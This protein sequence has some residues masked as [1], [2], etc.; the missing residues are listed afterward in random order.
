MVQHKE[1]KKETIENGEVKD[2]ALGCLNKS[3]NGINNESYEDSEEE[4]DDYLKYLTVLP[5]LDES[6][7]NRNMSLISQSLLNFY[8]A[9]ESRKEYN[10]IKQELMESYVPNSSNKDQ[11]LQ[12]TSDIKLEK[13]EAIKSDYQELAQNEVNNFEC[14]TEAKGSAKDCILQLHKAPFGKNFI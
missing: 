13:A 6:I 14:E 11:T 12:E 1:L 10:R 4:E 8:T 9:I 7:E 2:E 3:T 5:S